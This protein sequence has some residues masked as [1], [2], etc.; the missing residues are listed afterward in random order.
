MKFR[1]INGFSLIELLVVVAI[2]GVL[3][4]AGVVGYQTYLEGVR[5]DLIEEQANQTTRLI[6]T[7]TTTIDGQLAGPDWLNDA[8]VAG[9]CYGYVDELVDQSNETFNN[10]H[11]EID[12][13]PYFNGHDAPNSST[14]PE[15]TVGNV[16][17]TA[18]AQSSGF[19]VTVP[20]GKVLVFCADLDSPP[21][22][23]LIMT[24]AN[25]TATNATTDGPWGD[26]SSGVWQDANGDGLIQLQEIPAGE[27]PHPGS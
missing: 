6:E 27:C 10:F 15:W 23:T 20:P 21:Q 16:Q 13:M 22:D 25:S 18:V 17:P 5:N 7:H 2:I 4:G 1:N 11:D 12:T 8:N 3:A 14:T 19:Q 26:G 24:C 9:T